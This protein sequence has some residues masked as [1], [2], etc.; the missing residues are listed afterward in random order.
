MLCLSG[1]NYILVGCPWKLIGVHL[2]AKWIQTF[3]A[4]G[5]S[6]FPHWVKKAASGEFFNVM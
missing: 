1:L 3:S 4:Q 6:F 5:I 2:T